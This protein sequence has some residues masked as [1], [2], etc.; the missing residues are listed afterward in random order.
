MLRATLLFYLTLIWSTLLGFIILY[1]PFTKKRVAAILVGLAG[2][3]C[4]LSPGVQ[5]AV[6]LNK[7]DIYGVSAGVFWAIGATCIKRWPQSPVLLI[8][9]FQCLSTIIVSTLLTIYI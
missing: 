7:G 4:L 1:E 6:P 9:W 8:T 2:C 3:F 5:Q